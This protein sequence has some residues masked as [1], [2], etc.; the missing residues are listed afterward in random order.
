MSC[1]FNS[2]HSNRRPHM[3]HPIVFVAVIMVICVIFTASTINNQQP[4]TA[5]SFGYAVGQTVKSAFVKLWLLYLVY[6]A[7]LRL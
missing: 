5:Y 4:L 2:Q 6:K 3:R 7:I 1:S